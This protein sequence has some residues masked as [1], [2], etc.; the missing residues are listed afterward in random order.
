MNFF[1]S[2]GI[3]EFASGV[4]ANV[5][6]NGPCWSSSIVRDLA[7]YLD[8]TAS[9]GN[10]YSHT[11][12]FGF[13][14]RCVQE[15]TRNLFRAIFF[16]SA[17]YRDYMLGSLAS[18]GSEGGIWSIMVAYSDSF[19]LVFWGGNVSE[20]GTGRCRGYSLRC[21]QAFTGSGSG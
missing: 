2:A 3:C 12:S 17:G 15:L 13:G 1:P 11:R 7:G 19:R 21:V 4:R 20:Y 5:G 14:V 6:A 10:L 9:R 18:A 8:F 16:P